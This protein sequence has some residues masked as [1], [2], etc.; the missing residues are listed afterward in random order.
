M[1]AWLHP[2]KSKLN[3][4]ITNVE[5]NCAILVEWFRDNFTTLNPEK[6]HL[7]VSGY[8]EEM[9]FAKVGD[10]LIW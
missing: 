10:A 4:T 9:V 5:H 6:C 3:E 8:K 1:G 7:L 2:N